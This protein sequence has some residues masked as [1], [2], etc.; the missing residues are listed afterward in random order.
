MSAHFCS[1]TPSV[2]FQR[3]QRGMSTAGEVTSTHPASV[4]GYTDSTPH[5]SCSCV[6]CA[7]T[8]LRKIPRETMSRQQFCLHSLHTV[9]WGWYWAFEL[10]N[11]PLL[12]NA[13][14]TQ[15]AWHLFFFFYGKLAQP[16]RIC[17][18]SDRTIESTLLFRLRGNGKFPIQG[19]KIH[20]NSV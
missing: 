2:P 19:R 15:C 3:G 14:S 4:A 6:L 11:V 18:W 12:L 1:S 8:V 5:S 7:V 9:A 20:R 10:T 13:T 16:A 17:S